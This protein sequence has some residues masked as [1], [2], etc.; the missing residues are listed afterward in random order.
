MFKYDQCTSILDYVA[1]ILVLTL[2]N[3]TLFLESYV[4]DDKIL[5]ENARNVKIHSP[6]VSAKTGKVYT[7]RL[8]EANDCYSSMAWIQTKLPNY[9][10]DELR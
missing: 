3:Q 4:N 5:R 6:D 2:I 10:F 8:H 7:T 1:V 9:T